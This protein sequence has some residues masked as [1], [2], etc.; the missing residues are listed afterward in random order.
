MLHAICGNMKVKVYIPHPLLD[1]N[2]RR[3]VHSDFILKEYCFIY[4]KHILRNL[5]VL[6]I[7]GICFLNLITFL[8]IL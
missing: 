5:Y 1:T 8:I 3:P 7:I 4:E 2:K 6:D